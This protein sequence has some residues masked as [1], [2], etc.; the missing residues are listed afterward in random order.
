MPGDV[1]DIVPEDT[2]NRK[3]HYAVFPEDLCKTPILSTCPQDGVVLDPILWNGYFNEVAS[4]YKR[5]SIGID[6]ADDYIELA[7][8]ATMSKI[9]EC[10]TV[11][12]TIDRTCGKR[13]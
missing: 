8:E 12:G 5:K 9:S 3:K 7:K 10:F 1:W 11:S 13:L 6:L 2:Q 4:T